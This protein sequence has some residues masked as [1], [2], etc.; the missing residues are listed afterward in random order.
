MCR[1]RQ[2]GEGPRAN[3]GIGSGLAGLS[4][5][6]ARGGIPYFVL[7]VTEFE[8]HERPV[9]V[10]R[11]FIERPPE[12]CRGGVGGSAAECRSRGFAQH[13]HDLLV[14]ACGGCQQMNRDRPWIGPL[15]VQQTSG[16][17][18]KVGPVGGR[19][20]FVDRGPHNRMREA[21][22][23]SRNQNREVH[24]ARRQLVRGSGVDSSQ[25]RAH[26]KPRLVTEHRH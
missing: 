26:R 11:R 17:R 2:R 7:G 14:A 21:Q 24:E 9:P 8:Q 19:Q 18:V 20:V 23:L 15:L 25:F 22:R 1:P 16:A 4:K 6:A 12:Q 13:V 10:S 5:V 3:H